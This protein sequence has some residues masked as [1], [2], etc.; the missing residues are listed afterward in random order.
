MLK[1]PMVAYKVVDLLQE[2]EICDSGVVGKFAVQS[3]KKTHEFV[4]MFYQN[5]LSGLSDV[6]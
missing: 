1:I 5:G 2:G 4:L 3:A 6:G